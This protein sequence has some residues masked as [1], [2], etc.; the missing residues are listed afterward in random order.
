MSNPT[1]LYDVHILVFNDTKRISRLN[2]SVSSKFDLKE[3][4]A[5]F[6][7]LGKTNGTNLEFDKTFLRGNVD[8]CDIGRG[9]MGNFYKVVLRDLLLQYS[10]YDFGCPVKKGAYYA[11]NIATPD[12]KLLP[13][14]GI[15]G[16]FQLTLVLKA[17]IANAKGM[18]HLLTT[19]SVV[20]IDD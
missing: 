12:S 5:S 15:T 14:L 8:T 10:N 17:R 3:L 18:V 9:M 13:T 16:E 7:I 2:A 11:I 1:Y 4:R 20:S 19:N 6:N